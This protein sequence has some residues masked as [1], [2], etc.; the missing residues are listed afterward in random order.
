MI[1]KNVSL[2][3]MALAILISSCTSV[4]DEKIESETIEKNVQTIKEKH[5]E[6]DSLKLN[7]LDGIVTLNKGREVF[8]SELKSKMEDSEYSFEK[9]VVNEEKFDEQKDNIFNY[10]KAQEISFA[11]LLAEVDTVN[12]INDRFEKE[13][14]EIFIEIDNFCKER[15]KEIEEKEKKSDQIK[16]KLNEMVDLKIISLKETE[17]DYRDLV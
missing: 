14:Q 8:I 13:A 9:F 16:T 3:L 11:Q 4:L 2:L 10:F 5:P 12:N 1:K 15:Q 7:I 6:L 17:R